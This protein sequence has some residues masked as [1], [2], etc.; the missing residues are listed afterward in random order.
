MCITMDSML[1][2]LSTSYRSV[3]VQLISLGI[4][5]FA[6]FVLADPGPEL[7]RPRDDVCIKPSCK[8][9]ADEFLRNMK[10]S[11]SPCTDF[12][13]YACG[14]YKDH[15]PLDP[16]GSSTDY[17]KEMELRINNRIRAI[18][19]AP[20]TN[21]DS[22][23]LKK[24]KL[25]YKVCMNEEAIERSGILPVAQAV[26][27]QD[28]WPMVVDDWQPKTKTWMDIEMSYIKT[29]G[30]SAF[31]R[32]IVE[33]D[34]VTR[35]ENSLT[36]SPPK[37]ILPTYVLKNPDQH[38]N[39][40]VLY[41][42][43]IID[44][45]KEFVMFIDVPED[46]ISDE[47]QQIIRLEIALIKLKAANKPH[48]G[49]TVIR[50][51][52]EQ[53]QI[54]YD[55]TPHKTR[56]SKIIWT[57][58]VN[59]I[60]SQLNYHIP[61]ST[62]IKVEN[63]GYFQ[64]LATLLDKTPTRVIV[65]FVHWQYVR[66]LLSSC[67]EGMR[68]RYNVLKKELLRGSPRK[69]WVQ[70]L[71]KNPAVI[72]LISHYLKDHVSQ[73]SLD[74]VDE[75]INQHKSQMEIQILGT[76]WL[77]NGIKFSLYTKAQSARKFLG[78]PPWYRN[79]SIID[80]YY[81]ELEVGDN[82]FQN[83]LNSKKFTIYQAQQLLESPA[84]L[85]PESIIWMD[86]VLEVNAYFNQLLNS[87]IVPVGML[88]PPLFHGKD[89]PENVLYGSTGSIIGHELSHAFDDQGR[90]YDAGGLPLVW[91]PVSLIQYQERTECFVKQFNKYKLK[92]LEEIGRT[93]Y[94][95]GRST[96][97]ENTADTTG[98]FA[99]F[100]AFRHRARLRNKPFKKLPGLEHLT[101]DQLF[102][103]SFANIWCSY[104]KPEKMLFMTLLQASHSFPR[105]RVIGTL[106]NIKAF[107]DTFQCPFNSP[108]NARDK[109]YLWK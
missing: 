25:A 63:M 70:C 74:I 92:E 9:T 93:A 10:L 40:I 27:N 59:S 11:V 91:D 6:D 44:V 90:R 69:R 15:H 33:P 97:R 66:R 80:D 103:L 20:V 30:E 71:R 95:D 73:K 39:S 45:A 50:I 72:A 14:N 31:F 54:E 28:D 1:K 7:S 35:T 12:Y 76:S 79:T 42:N 96:E 53:L 106:S 81:T 32:G 64:Q 43:F 17:F 34:I 100:A 86:S 16:D 85:F 23:S 4:F 62:F 18:A 101:D 107:S 105:Y 67:D 26:N 55:K 56:N 8:V 108:M 13:E 109:C 78:N 47:A 75:M 24:A 98:I 57:D 46:K 37:F 77:D 22:V 5:I 60:F 68:E 61:P 104:I 3:Y 36:L 58:M 2:V 99:T 84:E 102:F 48:G 52:L 94:A 51:F 21:S 41:H 88:Y 29:L 89:V 49:N 87:L 38:R 19:E 83:E 82:H 65:N